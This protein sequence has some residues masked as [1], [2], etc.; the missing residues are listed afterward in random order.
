[1]KIDMQAVMTH[2]A[3]S[4]VSKRRDPFHGTYSILN[5]TEKCVYED[6]W[7][8]ITSN[9]RA[10]VVDDEGEVVSKSLKKFMNLSRL[11]DTPAE[12][13]ELADKWDGSLVNVWWDPQQSKW[14]ATTRGGWDG[15]QA[16][17]A[18]LWLPKL[19]L[20]DMLTD[21]TYLF[22]LCAPWNR[23]V[24][25]YPEE[26]LVMIGWV[27]NE[28][29]YEHSYEM[30]N[31]EAK[32]IGWE[33]VVKYWMR[34]PKSVDMEAR[35]NEEG[36]C[37]RWSNGLRA[38]IKYNQYV[39]LH[40]VLTGFSLHGIWE[41]LAQ[42]VQPDLTDLP[43]EFMKWYHGR[44]AEFCD[45]YSTLC[46]QVELEWERRP[47]KVMPEGDIYRAEARKQTAISWAKL[48]STVKASLFAKL[49]GKDYSSIVWKALRPHGEQPTFTTKKET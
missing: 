11:T 49:D 5:Y 36:Y 7:D 42:G 40:K 2:V 35:C 3:E 46:S 26:R 20:A 32:R 6:T 34:D 8:D 28:T 39:R 10:T 22:E 15:E 19:P 13:P 23:I 27:N 14:R 9:C 45:K 43:E 24:V 4:R 30:V 25:M 38:K 18:Q 33:D 44:I 48:H 29:W 37:V 31:I 17:A 47:V 1:M 21:Y 41:G 16:R 12:V